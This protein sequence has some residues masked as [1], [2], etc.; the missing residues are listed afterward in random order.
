MTYKL[1]I[2]KSF[3]QDYR[4]LNKDEVDLTDAII[5]KLLNNEILPE[6]NHDHALSGNYINF[7][8]CHIKPD[9]L[10]VY[11]KEEDILILTCTRVNSHSEIFSIKKRKK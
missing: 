8:E 3:K 7:R 6:H 9:L 5:K 10:L 2:T 4:K 11:K 1:K